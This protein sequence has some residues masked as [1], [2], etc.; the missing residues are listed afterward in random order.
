MH[1][2]LTP[3][4][5]CQANRTDYCVSSHLLCT[6][7]LTV[8][9]PTYLLNELL[10]HL[11]SYHDVTGRVAVLAVMLKVMILRVSGCLTPRFHQYLYSCCSLAGLV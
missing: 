7:P 5:L 11:L 9:L 6:F 1:V 2:V 10:A 4:C 8:Y 3:A